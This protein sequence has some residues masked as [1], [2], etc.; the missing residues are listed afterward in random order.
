MKDKIGI[1]ENEVKPS[2]TLEDHA[3][4]CR[5]IDRSEEEETEGEAMG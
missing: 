1:F 5:M 2:N 3:E 4:D